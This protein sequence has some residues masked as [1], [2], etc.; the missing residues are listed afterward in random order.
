MSPVKKGKNGW[1]ESDAR[2][3]GARWE[4]GSTREEEEE[5]EEA[6][7]LSRP[8]LELVLREF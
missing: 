7:F 4:G 1:L 2:G 6:T 8:D 5:E 3:V